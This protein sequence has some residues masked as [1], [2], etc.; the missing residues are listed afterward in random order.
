MKKGWKITIICVAVL[1]VL[2]IGAGF[3]SGNYFFNL[4]LNPKSDKSEVLSADHNQLNVSGEDENIQ[5]RKQAQ[6]W[7]EAS[8][9]NDI[10]ID[11]FDG[12]RLHAIEL[13][14]ETHSSR[15]AILCHGYT[16]KAMQMAGAGMPFY[17]QGFN[18]VMPDARGHGES[19][20]DYIGM[21]WHD[22]IDV[23]Y[24]ID[25]L[26][27]SYGTDIEI[28]LFGVS[29]GG[30]TVMMAAGEDLPV[31]VRAIVEDCGYSS[32]YDE[33]SYQLKELFGLAPFP[34]MDFANIVTNM[35]AGYTLREAS[36]VRQ[37]EK[38]K[39]PIL[40]IHGDADTF[41]PSSMVYD[42]YEAAAG[43]KEL[44]VVE[45]AGH[46]ASSSVAGEAYWDT[47]FRFID[48]YME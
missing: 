10:F 27:A 14:N 21:G 43:D 15:W 1:L 16:G 40:F 18:L 12:L 24:W 34:T 22:R 35:R 48:T 32:V 36:A 29:M 3:L 44:F 23:T 17:E 19:E 13:Q 20:G 30:A 6:E 25:Y 42:V 46:G 31:N 4:A 39:K 28:V 38:T 45:G 9:K 7:L 33:F 37:L 5:K 41:V 11:S 8:E 26:I 2:V 47:V